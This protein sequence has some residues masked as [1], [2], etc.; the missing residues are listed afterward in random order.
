MAHAFVGALGNEAAFG[1]SYHTAGEE[2][3]TWN[4][5]TRIVAEA[6][7]APTP[8]IVHIPTDLLGQVLPQRASWCVENFRYNNIFDNAAA[9][10]DLGFRYTVPF[11]EGARGV[12]GWLDAHGGLQDCD[13]HPFYDRVLEA[14]ASLGEGM[15][16]ATDELACSI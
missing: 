9:R 11:A 6:L 15:V 14:W 13:A 3:L 8:E 12:I 2:W 1:R 10:R 4:A 5:Y 7:G 16:A